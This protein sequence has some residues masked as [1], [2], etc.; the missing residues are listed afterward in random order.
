[1]S[2]TNVNIL[3]STGDLLTNYGESEHEHDPDDHGTAAVRTS[4]ATRRLGSR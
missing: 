4:C 2:P 1:M 3:G